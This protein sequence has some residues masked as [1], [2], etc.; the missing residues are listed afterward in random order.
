MLEKNKC[1]GCEHLKKEEIYYVRKKVMEP[2]AS[3]MERQP[4]ELL[5]I[6]DECLI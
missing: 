1:E 5:M 3:A 2:S 4:M 6:D